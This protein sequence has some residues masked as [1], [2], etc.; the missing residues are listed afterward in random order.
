M[1]RITLQEHSRLDDLADAAVGAAAHG[2]PRTHEDNRQAKGNLFEVHGIHLRSTRI[3]CGNRAVGVNAAA[4]GDT[5]GTRA[6]SRSRN[7][8]RR[9]P[10][11]RHGAG[12]RSASDSTFRSGADWGRTPGEVAGNRASAGDGSLLSIA[13]VGVTSHSCH[14]EFAPPP[15]PAWGRPPDT[16]SIV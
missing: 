5:C 3:R 4:A 11:V 7:G 9:V 12:R 2:A 6:A 8:K 13:V 1:V 16:L 10:G 14:L 15:S